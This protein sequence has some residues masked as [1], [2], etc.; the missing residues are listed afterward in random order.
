MRLNQIVHGDFEHLDIR[1]FSEELVA[2]TEALNNYRIDADGTINW[3]SPTKRLKASIKPIGLDGLIIKFEFI[4]T[5]NEQ[6]NSLATASELISKSHAGFPTTML[7]RSPISTQQHGHYLNEVHI[8]V[9]MSRILLQLNIL[10]KCL[11]GVMD[12]LMT[13]GS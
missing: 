8:N 3:Q 1:S 12:K 10:Q 13:A 6:F 11:S 4:Q 5:G 7:K 9:D 2:R